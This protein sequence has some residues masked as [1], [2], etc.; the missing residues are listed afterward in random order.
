MSVTS[1]QELIP[2]EKAIISISSNLKKTFALLKPICEYLYG[3][4]LIV[5]IVIVNILTLNLNLKPDEATNSILLNIPKGCGKTT[6]L[7]HI[8][9]K[10]NPKWFAKLPDKCF[11]SQFLEMSDNV[12]NRKVWVQ[13]DLITTFR[14]TSTKQREQ[15][16]GFHNT[17]LT[18]G[19]YSRKDRTVKGRIIAVYG[20]AKEEKMY[21]KEMFQETFTDRFMRVKLGFD[22]KTKREILEL[23]DNN[24]AKPM[25]KVVLPFKDVPVEVRIPK[26]FRSEI[27]DMSIELDRRGVMS[28]VRVQTFIKNFLKSSADINSRS[29]VCEDDLMLFKLV[30]PLHFG[31]NTGNVNTRVRMLIL[32][33]SMN[34]KAITGRKIK[35]ELV[36]KLG[37]SES[38]IQKSLSHLR[39]N[40]VIRFDKI[41]DGRGYDYLYW[42]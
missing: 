20:L 23:R 32:K 12:F 40:N 7:Y 30:L 21:Q 15:L 19:E 10:S 8:L 26:F 4:S 41:S 36:R 17:F 42:L 1:Q 37:C 9:Q 38:S 25:P 39:M 29:E 18:K 28:F 31:T 27:N 14:G 3:Y 13:D 35:D 6:L 2:S 33:R 11:E 34:G 24:T 16:M 22:E 5:I